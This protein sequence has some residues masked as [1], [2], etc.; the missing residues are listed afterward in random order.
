MKK[1]ISKSLSV[2]QKIQLIKTLK[3]S[4]NNNSRLLKFE[5]SKSRPFTF[6]FYDGDGQLI[7]LFLREN[8]AYSYL[9]EEKGSDL[10]DTSTAF[11]IIPN[12]FDPVN[13][14]LP[15]NYRSGF[16]ITLYEE[17][18]TLQKKVDI[19]KWSLTRQADELSNVVGTPKL[20]F[21]YPA[22]SE[23]IKE[24]VLLQAFKQKPG[25]NTFTYKGYLDIENKY[26]LLKLIIAH[27]LI[28]FP[29]S[30]TRGSKKEAVEE[31]E[32]Q[33]REITGKSSGII[34]YSTLKGWNDT[35]SR[36]SSLAPFCFYNKSLKRKF[37]QSRKPI[38]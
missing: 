1:T 37:A 16:E 35:F 31:Y 5:E 17:L 34:R 22:L 15:M 28:K 20:F 10:I 36:V 29:S 38:R 23:E 25:K 32:K 2:S 8:Q 7:W 24:K 13:L 3:N 19:L 6:G 14:S 18:L 27:Y 33:Y 9:Y 4:F 11:G 21:L 30:Q 12:N 26:E